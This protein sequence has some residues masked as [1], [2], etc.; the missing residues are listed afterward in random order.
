MKSNKYLSFNP[1]FVLVCPSWYILAVSTDPT[2]SATYE[3]THLTIPLNQ[4]LSHLILSTMVT[5][6]PINNNQ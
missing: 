4:S 5:I 1:L 3:E 2:I 6:T